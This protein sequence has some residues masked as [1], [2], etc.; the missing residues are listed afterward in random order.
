M[1]CHNDNQHDV[2]YLGSSSR[3]ITCIEPV[4]HIALYLR[5]SSCLSRLTRRHPLAQASS[6]QRLFLSAFM[7]ASKMTCDD[8]YSSQSW[9]LVSR[10][11]LTLEDVN[12]MEKELCE[13]LDWHLVRPSRIRLRRCIQVRN[14]TRVHKMITLTDYTRF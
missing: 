1:A 12:Q 9:C 7:I 4:C 5:H 13:Y 2:S 14:L 10:N 11:M 8:I 3:S 6:G